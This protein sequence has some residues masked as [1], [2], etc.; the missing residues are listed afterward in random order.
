MIDAHVHLWRIGQ[1]DCIWPTGEDAAIHRDFGLAEL[2]ATLDAAGVGQAVLVQSQESPRD[3]DWLLDLSRRSDRIAGVVGWADLSDAASVEE[4]AADRLLVGLRPMVQ[5]RGADW[6][7]GAALCAGFAAMAEH[8]LVLDALVRPAHLPSLARLAARYPQLSIVIDHA[9]K[10][11]ELA[12][13]RTAI[14]PLAAH[15]NVHVKFSGLLNEVAL[16]AVPEVAETLLAT[17][18]AERLLWG[19]DWPVLTQVGAYAGWLDMARDLIPANDHEGVFGGH[20]LRLYRL[21]EAARG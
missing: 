15:A 18:G 13:W 20:A 1:N 21:A 8:G 9:A 12:A 16:D 4:R 10:P 3:T 7:D 6:Y 19:S 2:I 17:F 5:G 14:A 11:E